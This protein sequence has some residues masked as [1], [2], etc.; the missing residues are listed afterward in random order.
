MIVDTL[1]E[2]FEYLCVVDTEFKGQQDEGQLNDPVCVVIKELKS[3]LSSLL[4]FRSSRDSNSRSSSF[5]LNSDDIDHL[6]AG[7]LVNKPLR[8]QSLGD[9]EEA[10]FPVDSNVS[11]I[12][13]EVRG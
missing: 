5:K 13:R 2:N 6:V 1:K 8:D 11:A 3:S 10:I 12:I 9:P 4:S 7:G